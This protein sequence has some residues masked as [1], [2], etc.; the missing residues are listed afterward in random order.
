MWENNKNSKM[1]YGYGSECHLLRFLGRHR[2][3]LD[4]VILQEIGI[5]KRVEWCDFGYD[6]N[7]ENKW[8]DA[9]IKG[10]DFI[11]DNKNIQKS[12]ENFWPHSGN[13]QNW[14]AIGRLILTDGSY[15]W[16]LVEAKAHIGEIQSDSGAKKDKLGYK[17]I[18]RA[19]QETKNAL[20]VSPERDWFRGYYQY[21]NR[22]VVS[23]FLNIKHHIPAR[24][25][26]IYFVGDKRTDGKIC[27]QNKE[28]WQEMLKNQDEYIG[29]PKN[30]PLA[31]QIHKLCLN[32]LGDSSK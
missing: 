6:K 31:K 18:E 23:Y 11:R 32:V 9:E 7:P 22:I 15:E 28:G 3:E 8:P 29:L 20:G 26:F 14:D 30:H 2:Q 13:V 10:L 24:L 27:P 17:M 4:K 12:W 5:G 21:A 1:G 25:L 19:F 16:L